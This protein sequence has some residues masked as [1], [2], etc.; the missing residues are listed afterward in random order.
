MHR[1]GYGEGKVVGIGYG[2]VFMGFLGWKMKN[3]IMQIEILDLS[4]MERGNNCVILMVDLIMLFCSYSYSLTY[5]F[6]AY[7][8]VL[9]FIKLI[10]NSILKRIKT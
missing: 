3:Q 4:E 8:R 9:F 7:R 6:K 2:V 5:F 10:R 1:I